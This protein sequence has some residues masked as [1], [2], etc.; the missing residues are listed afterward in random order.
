MCIFLA[1]SIRLP[2]DDR[3]NAVASAA[4]Q[5]PP[6]ELQ[7]PSTPYA[8]SV[9]GS[10]SASADRPGRDFAPAKLERRKGSR[11]L[12]GRTLPPSGKGHVRRGQQPG[13]KHNLTSSKYRVLIRN[14]ANKTAKSWD[15]TPYSPNKYRR[16][17]CFFAELRVYLQPNRRR[18]C[19]CIKEI[20]GGNSVS[21]KRQ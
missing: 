18:L 15:Y 19:T 5:L 21:T 3:H 9:R 16:I 10:W 17:A 20:I 7:S 8:P 6:A 11:G 14:Q 4:R 2:A 1:R 12:G 13:G